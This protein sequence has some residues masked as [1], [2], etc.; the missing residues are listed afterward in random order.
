MAFGYQAYPQYYPTQPQQMQN[1]NPLIWVQGEAGAKSYLVGP[2][3]TVAL[4]DSEESVIYRV[5]PYPIPAYSVAN[6]VTPAA[7]TA[8]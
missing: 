3:Q 7:T 4:W 1:V 8:A 5:A 2:G 6:P